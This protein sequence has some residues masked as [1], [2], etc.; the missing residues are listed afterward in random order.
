MR[1]N[2][3]LY[4]LLSYVD[5]LLYLNGFVFWPRFNSNTVHNKSVFN[6][7]RTLTTWH[8]PHSPAARCC[9][10]PGSNRSISPAGRALSNKPAAAACDGRMMGQTDRQATNGR[11]PDS[12]IN[13]APHTMRSVPKVQIG[14]ESVPIQLARAGAVGWP[15][16]MLK[17]K[18]IFQIK[19]TEAT[20]SNSTPKL[21]WFELAKCWLQF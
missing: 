18:Y 16:T 3:H 12:C 15:F 2:L 11:T 10:A 9:W 19:Y 6:F 8:C 21:I 5:F 7:L 17:Y 13:P 4:N 20:I 14:N 1:L